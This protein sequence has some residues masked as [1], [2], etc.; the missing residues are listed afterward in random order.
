MDLEKIGVGPKGKVPNLLH[1]VVEVPKGSKNKYEFDLEKGALFLSR[2][3]FTTN[4]YPGDYGFIPQTLCEDGDPVDVLVFVSEP[5]YP[6]T[7]LRV[8]PVALL[9]MIDE[10]GRDDKIIAVPDDTIDPRFKDIRDLKDLSKQMVDEISHFFM[11][12]K[13][14][15]PGKF[16]KVERWENAKVAKEFIQDSMQQYLVHKTVKKQTS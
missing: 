16:V 12:M 11:H 15:E 5:N 4:V 13:E 8:R 2:I 6:G 14:L 1:M 10:K 9:K 3:L 7:V